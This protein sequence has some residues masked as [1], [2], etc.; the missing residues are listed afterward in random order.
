M[1]RLIEMKLKNF[2]KKIKFKKV[3]KGIVRLL[4]KTQFLRQNQYNHIIIHKL[5]YLSKIIYFLRY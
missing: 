3:K 4:K 5:L 1:K 2:H